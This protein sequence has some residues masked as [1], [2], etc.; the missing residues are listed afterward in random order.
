MTT[1]GVCAYGLMQDLCTNVRIHCKA[2]QDN[3]VWTCEIEATSEDEQGKQTELKICKTDFTKKGA[4]EG[5][6]IDAHF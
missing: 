6:Q 5:F 4:Q 1:H 3:T 2:S